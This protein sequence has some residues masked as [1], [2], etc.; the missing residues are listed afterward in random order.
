M[1][2][3]ASVRQEALTE[4]ALTPGETDARALRN[5]L[6][7]F[8]TGVT[9]ITAVA[10]GVRAALTA[11]SFSTVS[12]DPPLVLWSL[13]QQSP[14]MPTFR[15]ADHFAVSVLDASQ[16]ELS[17]RFARPHPDKF[18]GV[19]I[20]EGLGGCPLLDGALAHF[21]C[22]VA[23]SLDGG[24]HRIFIGRV[25]RAAYRDGDP[26]VFAAGRFGRVTALDD[27]G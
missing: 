23:H 17:L 18:A 19:P 16:H 10:D 7:R 24:D 27:P 25:L 20:T 3:R 21:E 2:N 12:L 5:A 9:V 26:L 11:N 4:V 1:S 15:A 6:G 14:S 22:G 8:A 13:K